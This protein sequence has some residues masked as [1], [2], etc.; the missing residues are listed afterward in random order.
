MSILATAIDQINAKVYNDYIEVIGE[1]GT[2]Y[3]VRHHIHTEDGHVLTMADD[4]F[5]SIVCRNPDPETRVA[6]V[7]LTLA[8]DQQAASLVHTLRQF[9]GWDHLEDEPDIGTI[10]DL[11]SVQTPQERKESDQGTRDG[12]HWRLNPRVR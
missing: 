5:L 6:Y 9:T 3:K 1:S 4:K 2:V 8:H 11:E 7:L 10:T 12:S